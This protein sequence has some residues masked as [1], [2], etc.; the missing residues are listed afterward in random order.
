MK[1]SSLLGRL[2]TQGVTDPEGIWGV[3]KTAP[4]RGGG[5]G[6]CLSE[7]LGGIRTRRGKRGRVKERPRERVLQRLVLRVPLHADDE[8]RARQADSLDLAV[9]RHRLDDKCWGRLID[10]LA[11]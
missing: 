4:G 1:G 8:S 11:V 10:P 5:P 9:G 7:A 3:D 2:T 6:A